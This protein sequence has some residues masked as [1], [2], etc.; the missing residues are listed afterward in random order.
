VVD[1]FVGNG[2]ADRALNAFFAKS[3]ITRLK[4]L[5]VE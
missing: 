2:A 5:L 1:D 4:R 3:N